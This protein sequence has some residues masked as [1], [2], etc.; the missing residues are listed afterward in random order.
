MP[1]LSRSLLVFIIAGGIAF[2]V[3]AGLTL[4]LRNVLGSPI[5]ARLL[6]FVAAATV[7]WVINRE[8]GFRTGRKSPRDLAI[9]YI[10][11]FSMMGF[12]A[13]ANLAVFW[14]TTHV[15]PMDWQPAVLAGVARPGDATIVLGLVLGTL[16]GMGLNYLSSRRILAADR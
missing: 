9:E 7:T 16:T 13:A 4:C 6:G 14:A 11:Y 10:S 15:L 1:R 5:A 12:G 3:D 8:L 2:L